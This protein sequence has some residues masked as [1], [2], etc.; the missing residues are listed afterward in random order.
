MMASFKGAIFHVVCLVTTVTIL[1]ASTMNM[2]C[3][4]LLFTE[5]R[6]SALLDDIP[7]YGNPFN[8]TCRTL[9]QIFRIR[10]GQNDRW[11]RELEGLLVQ[12]FAIPFLAISSLV[13]LRKR[14]SQLYLPFRLFNHGDPNMH[15][16]T[17]VIVL[18]PCL[19][20]TILPQITTPEEVW[21]D[22]T[23]RFGQE[24]W[25]FRLS[26]F[27]SVA[28]DAA[29][30]ALS[31]FLVPVAK[32]SP[33]IQV[34]GLSFTQALV[35]HR[36]AGWISLVFT[37]LH[38]GLFL[39]DYG[40][41]MS[42]DEGRTGFQEILY[43][44]IPPANCWT[45]DALLF[46]TSD[47]GTMNSTIMNS[48]IMNSTIDNLTTTTGGRWLHE[49]TPSSGGSH[50]LSSSSH[51]LSSSS[52]HYGCNTHFF[53]FSGLVSMLAFIVLGIFSLPWVRRRTYWLFYS[54]HIPMAWIMLLSAIV[55]I[56]YDALFL[57]PNIIYY[58]A[59]T[60]SVWIQQCRFH[61]TTARKKETG[62]GGGVPI[63]SVTEIADSNGCYLVRLRRRSSS[64]VG[65]HY[66]VE[67]EEQKEQKHHC[68]G[69]VCK[70]CVPEI[71]S[72]WHPFSTLKDCSNGDLIFL[73]RPTG[74][75]TKELIR[76]FFKG[77]QTSCSTTA[78]SQEQDDDEEEVNQN[79]E[80]PRLLRE[81]RD[82]NHQ[83]QATLLQ[84]AGFDG[85][86]TRHPTP[87]CI[88]VDG[89]YPAEYRWHAK[90]V[91]QHDSVLLVAGGVGIV[92]FLP[93]LS[94]L[95]LSSSAPASGENHALKHVVL[96][97]YSREEG[98]ARYVCKEFLPW[99]LRGAEPIVT[100]TGN[101][102]ETED[103][104]QENARTVLVEE[105]G[106]GSDEST[107]ANPTFDVFI[108][109]TSANRCDESNGDLSASFLSRP[110]EEGTRDSPTQSSLGLNK[111]VKFHNKEDISPMKA[112]H[113]APTNCSS[114]NFFLVAW[115]GCLVLASSI[116]SWLFYEKATNT[117]RGHSILVRIHVVLLVLVLETS[118]SVAMVW[119]CTKGYLGRLPSA[120]S[121][122]SILPEDGPP[123]DNG[124][125][126]STNRPRVRKRVCFTAGRPRMD[127]VVKPV[128]QAKWP[129][130]MLCGPQKLLDS[131]KNAIREGRRQ[132]CGSI[133]STPCAFYDEQSDM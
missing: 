32:H 98:L 110:S 23:E 83:R 122:N 87:P 17:I 24:E 89:I 6:F 3:F 102:D 77:V 13:Y 2:S 105:G 91:Q 29:V 76:R 95:Y 94:S 57:V 131:V 86:S 88:L 27:A 118:F 61:L 80:S 55:H 128:V 133:T 31:L 106:D 99:F 67:E 84:R 103:R 125:S 70:I 12:G 49:G 43:L 66:S 81:D 26:L 28:G 48:T 37:V 50:H 10:G 129:G 5:M 65:D 79:V 7:T 46:R 78:A 39:L 113:V 63:E 82:N 38:G 9:F 58:F 44:V 73:I 96:H 45:L 20:V 62:G 72:I 114:R 71:S 41:S 112:T 1:V 42:S 85:S 8:W 40:T 69:G 34:F 92:P 117:G 19:V 52:H 54:V 15:F 64:S 132:C 14:D 51:H 101:E 97:W 21:N 130:A 25:Q 53:N 75:F 33:L 93:L 126:S 109:V 90:A 22:R 47:W 68:L 74:P 56:T 108:H 104:E 60:V 121:Y 124:T 59:P 11:W 107:R 30:M 35:F 115:F 127:N 111:T 116:L 123:D 36:N 18:L 100:D 16:W 119:L 4:I 120:D